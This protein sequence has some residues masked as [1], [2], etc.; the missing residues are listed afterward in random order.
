MNSNSSYTKSFAMDCMLEFKKKQSD[1]GSKNVCGIIT[2]VKIESVK[3]KIIFKK[4]FLQC[5]KKRIYLGRKKESYDHLIGLS[6]S[7]CRHAQI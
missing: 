2:S 4:N 3:K 1:T 6:H 7:T 5:Y